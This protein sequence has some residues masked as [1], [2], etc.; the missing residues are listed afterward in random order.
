[1]N[2]ISPELNQSLPNKNKV[3][4]GKNYRSVQT[5]LKKVAGKVIIGTPLAALLMSSGNIDNPNVPPPSHI[6]EPSPVSAPL[7]DFVSSEKSFLE[8]NYINA[9]GG[10]RVYLNREGIPLKYTVEGGK[11]VILDLKTMKKMR[12]KAIS[13]GEREIVTMILDDPHETGI[14]YPPS[15]EHPETRHLPDDVLSDEELNNRGIEIIQSRYTSLYIREGAFDENGPLVNF[16]STGRNIRIVLVDGPTVSQY[17]MKDDKYAK[18]RDLVPSIDEEKKSIKTYRKERIESL[19]KQL[20]L[21]PRDMRDGFMM[22]DVYSDYYKDDYYNS[23]LF[24]S[25]LKNIKELIAAYKNMKDEDV[26][27]IKKT[28]NPSADALG[29]Y[30]V[31]L[32]KSVSISSSGIKTNRYVNPTI[33]LAVGGSDYKQANVVFFGPDGKIHSYA[34]NFQFGTGNITPKEKDTHPNPADF[35]VNPEATSDNPKSYPYAGQ[36]AGQSL[37]HELE[38]DELIGQNFIEGKELDYSE[39]NTD[40]GAMKRIREAWE[41]WEKSGFTD[42]SGYHFVFSLPGGGYILTENKSSSDSTTLSKL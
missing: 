16:N 9:G 21:Q 23:E 18:V 29:L 22:P 39:Y 17:F 7:P 37:E 36:T 24:R 15:V 13:S 2:D 35:L 34:T 25:G 11:E 38:H 30:D 3:S 27:R 32:H 33:F 26:L 14:I 28:S 6:A 31:R 1:M 5:R 41:K 20:T 8:N 42:N 10:H 19:E 40:V 4:S 12:D